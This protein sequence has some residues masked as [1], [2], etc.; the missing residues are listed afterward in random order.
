MKTC[1]DL[2][3]VECGPGWRSI[4]EPL[5]ERCQKEGVSIFQ[6]KEKFGGLRFYVGPASDD[7]HKA[8]HESEDKSFTICEQCGAPG[9]LRSDGWIRTL[10]DE[11]AEGRPAYNSRDLP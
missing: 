1:Y 11:H 9:Q 10:C 8:I 6:I 5:M 3:G 4:I 2:F 7:L